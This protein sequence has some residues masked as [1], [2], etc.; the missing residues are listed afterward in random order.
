MNYRPVA[1]LVG[2]KFLWATVIAGPI[3]VATTIVVA[4]QPGE[5]TATVWDGVYAEAQA[6]RGKKAYEE[7]CA[8]CHSS[9]LT[10]GSGRAL[11]GTRFWNDWGEDS[12]DS[13]YNVIRKMM[14]RNEPG[15]LSEGT[16]IDIV[17]YILQENALP[18][19][20][21]ELTAQRAGEVQIVGREGPAEVP[22][23]SLVT[24]VGCLARQSA[25]VWVLT[26]AAAPVRTR[27]PD[28]SV[29]AERDQTVARPS[30]SHTFELMDMYA[31]P[32]PPVDQRVEVK[33]LLIRGAPDR[34]NVISLQAISKNCDSTP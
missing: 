22:N 21:D 23:F 27:N 7:S 33:G 15:K 8:S 20:G 24:V 4:Q 26:D 31:T 11:V 25:K 34:L 13:L 29:G 12:L 1:S 3:F 6:A 5:R 9:A 17:A 32:P 14:P 16:Y 30:G 18:P 2:S 28:A 19:G 10:G